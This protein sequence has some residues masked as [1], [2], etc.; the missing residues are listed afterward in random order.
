MA[1]IH[2]MGLPGA[3][4]STLAH[5]LVSHL[6]WARS[7]RIGTYHKRFPETEEGDREAWR[8]MQADME[9]ADWSKF[10]CES[11]G[12]NARWEEIFA[13]CRREGFVTLKLEC[14]RE[15]LIRR[16]A[17]KSVADQSHGDWSPRS[18]FR[19]K[20]EFVEAVYDDFQKQ[21]ADCILDTNRTSCDEVCEL[22]TRYLSARWNNR[23]EGRT[24]S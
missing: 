3:G 7:F 20:I 10:I 14:R 8:Q 22:A 6:N 5:R 13:R 11:T 4:K 12:L 15:E 2:L 19:N 18:R 9:A 17:L 1:V 24:K 23:T 21:A 16:I